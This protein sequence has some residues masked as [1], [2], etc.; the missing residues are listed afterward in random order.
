MVSYKSA[1]RPTVEAYGI[2]VQHAL[3]ELDMRVI[4]DVMLQGSI[5]I[6][7]WLAGSSSRTPSDALFKNLS[8]SSDQVRPIT[9]ILAA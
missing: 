5:E 8:K 4:T 2:H 3:G 1:L 9:P 6:S 7:A